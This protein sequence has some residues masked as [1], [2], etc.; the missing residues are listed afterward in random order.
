[1][2]AANYKQDFK[3][4][5]WAYLNANL[6]TGYTADQVVNLDLDSKKAPVGNY[7]QQSTVVD[8][9]QTGAGGTCFRTN[10]IHTIGIYVSKDSS[11]DKRQAQITLK[12]LMQSF[13]MSLVTAFS[14]LILLKKL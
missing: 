14:C 9:S 10:F 11:A 6:P 4:D 3:Q 2:S 1:M 7:L 8:R 5:L 13:E 12:E